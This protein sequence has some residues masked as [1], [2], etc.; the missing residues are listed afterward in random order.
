MNKKTLWIIV[1]IAAVVFLGVG[2]ILVSPLFITKEIHEGMEEIMSQA[3]G[4]AEMAV[5][6]SG[7]FEGLAFHN[8]VGTAKL[9]KTGDSY[10][11]RFEDDFR[12]TNGPYLVVNLGKDG[13]R[14][15]DAELGRLKGNVG[16]QNYKIPAGLDISA[17][18]EVWIWC[19]AFSVPFGKA[20]LLP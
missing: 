17:Y 13:K 15:G 16:S 7:S 18:N 19:K 5:A 10:Y 14:D 20:I 9:I 2:Y 3:A 6:A 8:A 12:V 11:V 1:V 4:G